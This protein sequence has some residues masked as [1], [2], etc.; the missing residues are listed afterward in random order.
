MTIEEIDIDEFQILQ[1]EPPAVVTPGHIVLYLVCGHLDNFGGYPY[2]YEWI[3]NELVIAELDDSKDRCRTLI[4]RHPE[5]FI[6]QWAANADEAI[7]EDE[8]EEFERLDDAIMN[9]R[10][11]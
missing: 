5:A 1:E 4:T 9:C 3:G 6:V 7:R 11:D 2:D 8:D 10:P